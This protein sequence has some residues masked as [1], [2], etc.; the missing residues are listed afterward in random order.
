MSGKSRLKARGLKGGKAILVGS[1]TT[2][3]SKAPCRA[4]EKGRWDIAADSHPIKGRRG[5]CAFVLSSPACQRIR[6]TLIRAQEQLPRHVIEELGV[7]H[8]VALPEPSGL[9]CKAE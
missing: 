3:R 7:G 1:W 2:R 5:R 9:L 8:Q 4:R 6:R